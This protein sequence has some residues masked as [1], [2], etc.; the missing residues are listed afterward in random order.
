MSWIGA[1]IGTIK[2][3]QAVSIQLA[4]TGARSAC[5]AAAA[6]GATQQASAGR[7]TAA[8]SARRAAATTWVSVWPVVSRHSNSSVGTDAEA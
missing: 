7:R 6:G 3:F 2:N 5:F 8:A 4:P 1:R